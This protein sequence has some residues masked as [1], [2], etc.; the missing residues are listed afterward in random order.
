MRGFKR[1][2]QLFSL[3]GLNCGLCPMKLSGHCPGCGGGEGN[4]SCKLARCSLEHGSVAYCF[5]C[6][7][8]PCEKYKGID[9]FDSFITHRNQKTDIEKARRMGLE[10]YRA[11]QEERAAILRFLL[12]ACNDGRRKNLL[13]LAANLLELLDLRAIRGQAE[14]MADL[15]LEERGRKAS[16]LLRSAAERQGISL[17]LRK[18]PKKL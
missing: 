6:G 9:E 8:F 18:K 16:S 15:S 14:A 5:Q 12:E 1:E 3:C 17:K 10:R 11:E 13:C 7:E 2:D 4:Q